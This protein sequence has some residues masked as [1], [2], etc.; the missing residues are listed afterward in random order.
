MM[1]FC[2]QIL[3]LL[4]MSLTAYAYNN[5]IWYHPVLVE[6]CVNH[7]CETH[8]LDLYREESDLCDGADSCPTRWLIIPPLYIIAFAW[9]GTFL[10]LIVLLFVDL[11][12]NPTFSTVVSK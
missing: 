8:Q 9:A 6:V 10:V 3:G 7:I 12:K 2:E 11:T 1:L 4:A 5:G